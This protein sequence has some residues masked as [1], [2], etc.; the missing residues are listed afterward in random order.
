MRACVC[1]CVELFEAVT[2]TCFSVQA[3][4]M[5]E[6]EVRVLTAS[7]LKYINTHAPIST[8]DPEY[9]YGGTLS[10]AREASGR[11]EEANRQPTCSGFHECV[12]SNVLT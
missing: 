3:H 2:H 10:Q 4:G 11:R 9:T 6:K 1:V 12:F 8:R 5:L 7:Q